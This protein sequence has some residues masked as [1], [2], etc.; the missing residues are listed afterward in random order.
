VV[1]QER[2]AIPNGVLEVSAVL[3]G[4]AHVLVVRAL[5]VEDVIQCP[6]ASI[7]CPSGTTDRWSGGMDLLM[8]PLLPTIG[9]LVRVTLR[10]WWC[11]FR[12][13]DEVLGPLV[14]GDVEVRFSK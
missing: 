3:Q 11:R 8:R 13:P 6:L 10:C 4:V 14:S 12:S 9:L 2:S 7:G 5:G 1:E